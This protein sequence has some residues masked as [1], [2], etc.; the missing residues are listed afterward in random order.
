V[1]VRWGTN[2]MIRSPMVTETW[3]ALGSGFSFPGAGSYGS[4]ERFD[5]TV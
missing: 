4:Q 3:P 1:R 5:F 2:M